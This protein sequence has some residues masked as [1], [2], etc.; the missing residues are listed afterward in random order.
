MLDLRFYQDN[1]G[2]EKSQ[3]SLRSGTNIQFPQVAY[4]AMISKRKTIPPNSTI[5][6][7][8]SHFLAVLV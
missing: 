2:M 7:I 5:K 3:I 8:M 6:T 1:P 4:S